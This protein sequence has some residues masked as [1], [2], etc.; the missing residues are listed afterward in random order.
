MDLFHM[1]RYWSEEEVD[2]SDEKEV[3][4]QEEE[5]VKKLQERLTRKRKK[6]EQEEVDE[7]PAADDKKED[8]RGR[9]EEDTP[10]TKKKKKQNRKRSN[11]SSSFSTQSDFTILGSDSSHQQ[12]GRKIR[13]VLPEW[14]LNPDV[15]SADLKEGKVEVGQMEGLDE[16]LNE[17]LRNRGVTHFFPVQRQVI[18]HLLDNC[19]FRLF[20]PSDICVS[21]PTGS[22]KTLA[23]ILPLIQ[24]LRHRVVPRVRALVVLP[25][26]DLA[27]QV[28]RVFQAYAEGTGLRVKLMSVAR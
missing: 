5:V 7:L 9:L 13:C 21:A 24:A 27:Q 17:R 22:G 16:D 12:R 19:S 23:F 26:Q 1:K 3:K 20:R 8:Q 25:V 28:H 2:K 4:E 11:E 10:K 15:V 6:T 14:L 18:P